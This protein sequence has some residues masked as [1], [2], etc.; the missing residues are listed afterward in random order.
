M[1]I[2]IGMV[3]TIIGITGMLWIIISSQYPENGPHRFA[4]WLWFIFF[5]ICL[6]IGP[7]VWIDTIKEKIGEKS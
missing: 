3:L 4:S 2:L 5:A 6:S 7:G 1:K